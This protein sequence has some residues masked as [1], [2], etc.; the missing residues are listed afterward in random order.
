M[1][2]IELLELDLPIVE[3]SA[4]HDRFGRAGAPGQ[5]RQFNPERCSRPSRVARV[6]TK[7]EIAG[8]E[9]TVDTIGESDCLR[10]LGEG[11]VG[12]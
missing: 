5:L 4:K 8:V 1:F 2:Y 6:S 12:S 7:G 11:N 10:R 9:Q 3:R